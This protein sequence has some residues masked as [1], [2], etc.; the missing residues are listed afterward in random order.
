MA[1]PIVLATLLLGHVTVQTASSRAPRTRPGAIISLAKLDPGSPLTFEKIR[2][3]ERELRSTN[4]FQSVEV[5]LLMAPD[6]AARLMYWDPETEYAD[7]SITLEEK[8]F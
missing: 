2:R 3:A 5:T 8:R 6:D 4:L 7:V 1:V